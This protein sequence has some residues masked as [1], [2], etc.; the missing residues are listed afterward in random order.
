MASKTALPARLKYDG[1]LQQI[2]THETKMQSKKSGFWQYIH[3]FIH[4]IDSKKQK[5]IQREI[6]YIP[7]ANFQYINVQ[8]TT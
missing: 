4:L 8:S 1:S 2:N 7:Y 6:Q 3:M 5:E